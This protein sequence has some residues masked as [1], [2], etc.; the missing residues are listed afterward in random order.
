MKILGG[1][2]TSNLEGNRMRRREYEV[3]NM[4]FDNIK[5]FYK[6]SSFQKLDTVPHLTK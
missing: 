1:D 3:H 4:S 5:P 6:I 2:Y